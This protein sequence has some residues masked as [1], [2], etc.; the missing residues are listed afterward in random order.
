MFQGLPDDYRYM[1]FVVGVRYGCVFFS[2]SESP[3][4]VN[5]GTLISTRGL[6][7]ASPEIFA[8]VTNKSGIGI[9]RT[10]IT[11]GGTLMEKWI[12]EQAEYVSEAGYQG[13]VGSFA[14][15]NNGIQ[16]SIERTR[17]IIRAPQDRLQQTVSQSWSASLDFG[18]PSDLLGGQT[19]A[20]FKRA[21]V[22][23]SGSQY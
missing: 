12:D 2:N 4:S 9:I 20:R 18:V 5:T 1:R 13:K 8:E 21:V 11:G 14:I 15:V 3:T 6:A 23:E 16:V 19:S 22:I 10:I 17:Y 7:F